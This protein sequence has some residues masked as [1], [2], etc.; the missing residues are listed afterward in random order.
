MKLP[1]IFASPANVRDVL[2]GKPI[3]NAGDESG[4]MFVVQSG[5]VDI[6][7]N[8]VLVETVLP[9]GFF[10]EISLIEDS[11]RS[12]D[13]IA[14]TDCKLLPVNRHHFLSMVDELPQFAL[15]VMK[16]MADRLRKADKR[17]M[18]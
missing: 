6:L 3:F 15:Y 12:A 17:A 8:G 4:E 1:D 16:G 5:A 11:L 18:G 2:Q 9:E 13:A 7:I 10:G 14:R